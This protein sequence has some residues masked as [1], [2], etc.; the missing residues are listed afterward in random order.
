MRKN[1]V[2]TGMMGVGKSTVGKCLAARLSFNFVD[3]DKVIEKKESSKELRLISFVRH[4]DSLM[5]M[6]IQVNLEF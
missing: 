4:K 3:I 2:L 6:Q 5:T 1:L